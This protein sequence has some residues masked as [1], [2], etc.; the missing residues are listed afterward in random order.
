MPLKQPSGKECL[1]R[2]EFIFIPKHAFQALD[3]SFHA[4]FTRAMNSILGKA[5]KAAFYKWL[6]SLA[7]PIALQNLLTSSISFVDTLMI[8][9]LG[10]V[11]I[12][13]VGLGNQLFFLF[14]IF[15]FG[16]TS[17][18]VIFISQYWG[19][20]SLVGMQKIMGLS[21]IVG[22]AGAAVMA[23]PSIFCPQ[24]LLRMFTDNIQVI[25]V[26][27]DYLR[28]VGASYFFVCITNTFGSTLRCTGDA[29]TPM[30]IGF[31]AMIANALLDWMMIFGIAFFPVMGTKGAAW[32]T[33]F[34]R[35]MEMVLTVLYV[36]KSRSPARLDLK[37]AFKLNWA[38]VKTV[39]KTALPVVLNET[40]WA[41]G[42]TV[43]K[44]AYARM[45]V[46]V[47]ASVNISEAINNLFFVMLIGISN[48]TNIVVGITIGQHKKELAQAYAMICIKLSVLTGI[49]MGGLL[50]AT[51]SIIP[52]CFNVSSSIRSTTAKSLLN[53]SWQMPVKCYNMVSITGILRSGGDTRFAL[54]A[55]EIGIWF[56]GVPIAWIS[57]LVW[58]LPIWWVYACIFSEEL[59]KACLSLPRI[60]KRKWINDLTST[61]SR[62]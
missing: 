4:G 2:T 42:M 30:K 6:W 10:S 51:S 1:F 29:E 59:W 16:I 12:A 56:V 20:K 49:L 57:G 15:Y 31:I 58:K 37:I 52:L 5:G 40:L 39:L 24:V 13:G 54:I 46:D 61:A 7:L 50:A 48:A 44:M 32:A 28:I 60:V 45:G 17:S 38:F 43:Y 11:E 33:L 25:E 14:N 9:Q 19:S 35:L 62:A 55:E 34:S 26:G 23:I 47:L 36:K 8:G 41:L 21:L 22:S 18:S 27:C 53:L 3:Q